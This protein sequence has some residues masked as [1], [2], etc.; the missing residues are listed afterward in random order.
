MTIEALPCGSARRLPPARLCS[1]GL[2]QGLSAKP[3]DG[4]GASWDVWK[5]AASILNQRDQGRRE[6]D[7][8]AN[9]L[10][11]SLHFGTRMLACENITG[12]A[13]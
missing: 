9:D 6:D 13:G 2:R 10:I 11:G 7:L 8:D 5:L 4:L 1:G 3:P 12:T